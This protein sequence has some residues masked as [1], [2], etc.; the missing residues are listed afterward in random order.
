MTSYINEL[1]RKL[2]LNP[3]DIFRYSDCDWSEIFNNIEPELQD[4]VIELQEL[5]EEIM[6]EE[7]YDEEF[8]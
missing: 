1:S 2:G 6:A 8:K 3:R 4:D 7:A 5:C